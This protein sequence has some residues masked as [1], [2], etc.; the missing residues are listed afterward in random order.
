MLS[1]IEKISTF[2]ERLLNS[3]FFIIIL[4]ICFAIW[5][6]S[7]ALSFETVYGYGGGDN[8]SHYFIARYAFEQPCLFFHHWGKP[9]FTILA[10]PWA[11]LG[12]SG[13][14]F[15]NIIIAISSAFLSFQIARKME[16]SYAGIAFI[17]TMT[18]PV[19]F[20]TATTSLTE[21]LFALTITF[22]TYYFI[23]QRFIHSAIIFSFIIFIRTE[24]II[25]MPILFLLFWFN[26]KF[27]ESL[28]LLLGFVLIST[29][30][31][32]CYKDFFWFFTH[33]PYSILQ[34]S[35]Y[36]K[37]ELL[38]FAKNYEHI[39]GK[40]MVILVVA[41]LIHILWK[42][43]YSCRERNIWSIT[44]WLLLLLLPVTYF[45]AHSIVWYLGIGNSMGLFRVMAAII[46]MVAILSVSGL[47]TFHLI[48]KKYSFI[49]TFIFIPW[50]IFSSF[51]NLRSHIPDY[52]MSMHEKTVQEACT[53]IKYA[54]D[55][56]NAKIYYFDPLVPLFLNKN[57]FD[58]NQIHNILE[59]GFHAEKMEDDAMLFWDAHF[60][61][62]E[63]AIPLDSLFN[64]P[65][66]KPILI[67][68]PSVPFYTWKNDPY[69]I[70]I[71][72]KMAQSDQNLYHP[73]LYNFLTNY[74]PSYSCPEK[75]SHS[76]NRTFEQEI[77]NSIEF[78]GFFEY[79]YHEFY[80]KNYLYMFV[81]FEF[82][83]TE[84]PTSHFYLVFSI[85][86]QQ[87]PQFYQ[88]FP[89]SPYSTS[90]GVWSYHSSIIRL[91]EPDN[92][93]EIFKC[94]IWNPHKLSFKIRNYNCG[95]FVKSD[96]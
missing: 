45:A 11:T 28:F 91:P 31:Y 47:E 33:S 65:Y 84:T 90:H 25:F 15:F 19:F 73:S 66:L 1:T 62:N 70:V 35:P 39:F 3:S 24:G 26:K 83:F 58:K 60:G 21:P 32:F 85:E 72:R 46:P 18:A 42:M 56:R 61:P 10:A 37:G 86:K 96:R 13:V 78:F 79:P 89:I 81:N 82:T 51:K 80:K 43:Y 87:N 55:F 27:F 94:Y 53:L 12:L 30:G 92:T 50:L 36:G 49:V 41:G 38:H 22:G 88:A 34:P 9:V 16:L 93:M 57:P 8:L 14:Y 44:S 69:K 4:S 68:E 2:T 95:I 74:F 23:T 20:L 77:S 76:L 40:P 59:W 63:G 7:S 6:L 48:S 52:K 75:G 54:D 71:F 29:G 5:L 17:M 64:T 67:L